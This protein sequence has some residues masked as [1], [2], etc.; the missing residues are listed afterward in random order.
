MEEQHTNAT[1]VRI[2]ASLLAEY[3]QGHRIRGWFVLADL[4]PDSV[5]D[6]RSPWFHADQFR[7]PR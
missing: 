5:R 2:N 1:G 7:D 6:P 4:Y 3:E